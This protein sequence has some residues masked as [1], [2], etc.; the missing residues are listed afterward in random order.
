[1]ICRKEVALHSGKG[2]E[3]SPAPPHHHPNSVYKEVE[4]K[5]VVLD[6]ISIPF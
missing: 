4:E 3:D 5:S 1:M 6:D 2:K